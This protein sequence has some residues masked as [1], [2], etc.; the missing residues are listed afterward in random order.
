MPALRVDTKI[1][2]M[3]RLTICLLLGLLWIGRAQGQTGVQ[4]SFIAPRGL[5]AYL[6]KPTMGLEVV[7]GFGEPDKLFSIYASVG[8]TRYVSARDTF[9]NLIE[10]SEYPHLRQGWEVMHS[11][12]EVPIA[13]SGEFRFLKKKR[14]SPL[15]GM[16]L[17]FTLIEISQAYD[18]GMVAY[19]GTDNYWS[20]GGAFKVGASYVNKDADWQ[21]ALGLNRNFGIIGTNYPILYT[22][23]FI[24]VIHKF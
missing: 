21:V 23:P 13:L 7:Q 18:D 20:A 8:V 11:R 24:R 5:D 14:I 22:K 10:S 15:A 19:D 1:S 3:R 6:Y 12:W 17:S 9:Y 16:E 4:L 2:H